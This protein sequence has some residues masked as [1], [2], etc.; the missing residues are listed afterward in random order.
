[1]DKMSLYQFKQRIEQLIDVFEKKEINISKIPVVIQFD[2]DGEF[3]DLSPDL[4]NIAESEDENLI[5]VIDSPVTF[6]EYDDSDEDDS[7]TND[8]E[9]LF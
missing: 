3:F 6:E 2:D 1:M 4:I 5:I 7:D 8:I 9:N